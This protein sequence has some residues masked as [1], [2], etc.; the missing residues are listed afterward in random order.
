MRGYLVV[1]TV[2]TLSQYVAESNTNSL[3][4]FT[5]ASPVAGRKIAHLAVQLA[6]GVYRAQ[7][8]LVDGR[9]VITPG[10]LV[11]PAQEAQ[12]LQAQADVPAWRDHGAGS[13]GVRGYQQRY[14][15][16][17]ESARRRKQGARL[18]AQAL[19]SLE[20]AR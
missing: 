13:P 7:D 12:H 17:E 8:K 10:R 16:A 9:L 20:E 19:R 4:T 5:C 3:R 14:R 6:P 11:D 1:H 18:L 15:A 2:P